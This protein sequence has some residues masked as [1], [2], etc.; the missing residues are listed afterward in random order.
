MRFLLCCATVLLISCGKAADTPRSESPATTTASGFA[1]MWHVRGY[2]HAGDSIVGYDLTAGA[3]TSGWTITFPNRPPIAVR[4]VAMTGDSVV[5][6]AG[7]YESVL[8]PGVQV[9]TRAVFHLQGDTLVGQTLA[10]YATT[11]ADSV[12]AIASKGT[13]MQ[14]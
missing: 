12:L 3:D 4:V 9:S 13:R 5:T 10:H 14:H 8:R 11:G 1:G 7:P 6:E 2:N